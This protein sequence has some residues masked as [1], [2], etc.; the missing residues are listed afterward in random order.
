MKDVIICEAIPFGY[1]PAAILNSLLPELEKDYRIVIASSG[2]TYEFFKKTKYETLYCD[3]YDVPG[4]TE[5]LRGF[6]G[7]VKTVFSVE[8]ER[9]MYAAKALNIR[10][11]Y[12]DLFEFIW[13]T[14]AN[15]MP[16][17][18][19]YIVYQLFEDEQTIQR[20]A[21]KGVTFITPKTPVCSKHVHADN[22][23]IH[24][25]GLNS[26]YIQ[27]DLLNIYAEYVSSIIE[28]IYI[29]QKKPIQ[30]ITSGI[31]MD[32]LKKK[33]TTNNDCSYFADIAYSTF[34]EM[35]SCSA[36]YITTPGIHSVLLGISNNLPLRI[37]HPANYTQYV[38]LKCFCKRFGVSLSIFSKHQKDNQTIEIMKES[39]GLKM[40]KQRLEYYQNPIVMAQHTEDVI[41]EEFNPNRII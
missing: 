24:I 30:V 16:Y 38:Q 40:I 15:Y 7:D 22:I 37:L 11:V 27:D 41:K 3:S 9:Y 20:L 25:G 33:V 32:I 35:V 28:S 8:N 4:I 39:D 29:Q 19:K 34:V 31:F 13:D 6:H 23:T 12:V 17:V 21:K 26:K 5:F 36:L 2:S 14:T 18:D 1:G 10:T